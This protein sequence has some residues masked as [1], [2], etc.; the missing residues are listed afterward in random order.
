VDGGDL[1]APA[2]RRPPGAGA[3]TARRHQLGGDR[4]GGGADVPGPA[5][6]ALA[7]VAEAASWSSPATST[8][9]GLALALVGDDRGG[10]VLEAL[11]AIQHDGYAGINPLFVG[12]HAP[13]RVGCN[14]HVP[15]GYL[16]G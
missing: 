6:S 11:A 13:R 3:R 4:G 5:R 8:A 10:G 16:S 12:P 15:S 14:G 9:G 2:R 1:D 7:L